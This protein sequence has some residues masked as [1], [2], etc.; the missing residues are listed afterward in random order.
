[1]FQN[2]GAVILTV[3]QMVTNERRKSDAERARLVTVTELDGSIFVARFERTGS[4]L[5]DLTSKLT[6][7]VVDAK[8]EVSDEVDA[9]TRQL[10]Q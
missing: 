2:A 9:R 6:T 5:V 4:S 7:I 3:A 8:D 1:M 10:Q